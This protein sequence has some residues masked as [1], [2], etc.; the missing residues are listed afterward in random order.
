D[1]LRSGSVPGARRLAFD[2]T[3]LGAWDTGFL[4][5][6]RHL[7][8]EC[9][10]AGIEVDHT[11]LPV[12]VEKRLELAA[13]VPMRLVTPESGRLAWLGRG[14]HRYRDGRRRSARLRR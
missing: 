7:L 3:G 13:A 8:D 5:F 11:G 9:A 2:T 1:V 10:R 4:T 14:G 6:I 12:D